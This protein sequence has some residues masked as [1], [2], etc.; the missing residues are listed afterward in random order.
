MPGD[1]AAKMDPWVAPIWGNFETILGHET[2]EELKADCPVKI[3][4][5]AYLRGRTLLNAHILVDEAQNVTTAQM[6]K[7][8]GRLGKNSKMVF[9]G[10]SRQCDLKPHSSGLPFLTW[11]GEAKLQGINSIEFTVNHRHP[12]LDQVLTYYEVYNGKIPA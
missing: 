3:V 8:L 6:E 1:L 9:S 11:L 7:I 12:I 4:P 2:Y 5:F 10:D